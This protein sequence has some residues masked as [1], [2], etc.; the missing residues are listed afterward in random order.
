MS[1]LK[2]D[3]C[4][5]IES[6]GKDWKKAKRRADREDRVQRRDLERMRSYTPK[7]TIKRA[8]FQV[9][10]Q[11][12][13]KASANGTLPA[14][15][16]QIMYAA[17][18]GVLE[19]TGGECWKNSSYFTQTLL[20]AYLEEHMPMWDVVYDARGKLIEPHTGERVNLGTLEVRGYIAEW[21]SDMD[22]P[23]F[24]HRISTTGPEN[25]YQY[26]L[27]VEKEGFD[28]LWRSVKLAE[29]WDLAIMSTKGMSVIAARELV[30]ELARKDV[31]ILVLRDF[32]KA[33]FSIVHTLGTSSP[34]YQFIYGPMI[35]DLGLRLEDVREMGLASESVTYKQRTDPCWNLRKCGATEEECNFLVNGQWGSYWEGQRVELNAM[36]S[37]QLVKWLEGKLR[38]A[39]V[40]KVIPDDKILEEAYKRAVLVTR[41][42]KAIAEVQKGFDED[43][44]EV[45]DDLDKR[46]REIIGAEAEFSWDAE[47]GPAGHFKQKLDMQHKNKAIA[48]DDAIW[49]IASKKEVTK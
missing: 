40:E 1:E 30:D 10:E 34:R 49:Q 48:W 29:R 21:K 27:F 36:T 37:D 11:A 33:G 47:M 15:A 20:P 16:R 42:E 19:L 45:P 5:A 43:S 6:V 28:S 25:R 31:I 35:I 38:E 12:Y 3:I 9:M 41:A 4:T 22:I 18:P 14:N 7:M 17:R 23:D 26:A 24:K 32:D 44:I 39:G 46:V 13:M 2:D 8:A